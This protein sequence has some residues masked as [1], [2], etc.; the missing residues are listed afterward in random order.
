MPGKKKL[1]FWQ[2]A[3]IFGAI[4]ILGLAAAYGYGAR[5]QAGMMSQSMGNMMGSMHLKNITLGD[6]LRRE[7][8]MEMM[9]GQNQNPNQAAGQAAQQRGTASHSGHHGG[10]GSFLKTAHYL[11]TG[12]IIILLP[13]IVAGTIF[14]AIIWLK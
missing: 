13:F 2:L 11:T 7:E 5:D 8:Q 4:T 9:Q 1:H 6:L 10:S 12:T 3:I 14:L